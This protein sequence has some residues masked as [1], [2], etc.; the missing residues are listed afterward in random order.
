MKST[1]R[2]KTRY[3]TTLTL[4]AFAAA[5][6]CAGTAHAEYITSSISVMADGQF[7]VSGGNIHYWSASSGYSTYNLST[8][9]TTTIGKP[10]AGTSSNGFGDPFGVYDS[11]SGTFYTASFRSGGSSYIYR[12]DSASGSWLQNSGSTYGTELVNA[13]GG[14]TRNGQLY[15]SGLVEPW[16]GGYGQSTFISLFDADGR[17]DT[18]IETANNSAYLAV[19]GDG[20]V[21]YGIFNLG[22]SS[23]LYYW[24]AEQVASVTNDLYAEGAVD[25]FLTLADG[26]I[27]LDID[28]G[29]NGLTVDEAGNIF[30][31]VNGGS[32][33]SVVGM[34]D[35][36]SEGYAVIYDGP[37]MWYGA[38]SIDGDFNDGATLYM[39]NYGEIVGIAVPEPATYA[40]LFGLFAL[41]FAARRQAL[42]SKKA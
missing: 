8:G 11:S 35:D 24:T 36:S 14:A 13:Y 34:V 30:F 9:A 23:S 20:G 41:A 37:G 39:N 22:G 42:S 1:I 5:A 15:V 31:S 29:F 7:T 6:L 16:N 4:G 2:S 19:D 12:H 26:Q 33:G 25:T 32:A 38:L 10:P 40:A 18:L 28:G 21:Y 3:S 17:Q 27:L